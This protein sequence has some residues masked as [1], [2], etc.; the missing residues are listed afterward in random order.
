MQFHI[1]STLYHCKHFYA[2]SLLQ[3]GFCGSPFRFDF[4]YLL[5]NSDTV[6]FLEYVASMD[7]A[8]AKL[9]KLTF[10]PCIDYMH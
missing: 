8:T 9:I 6:V 4:L 3:L 7:A 1:S 5:L 10:G 2:F